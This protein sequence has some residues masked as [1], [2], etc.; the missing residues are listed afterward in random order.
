MHEARRK[1]FARGGTKVLMGGGTKF[2]GMGGPPNPPFWNA[3]LIAYV[4]DYKSYL[5]LMKISDLTSL[6]VP[7]GTY[8][9]LYDVNVMFKKKLA[10]LPLII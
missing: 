6:V 9:V 2:F 5:V 3:L 8:V 4:A 7:G 10:T 1:F